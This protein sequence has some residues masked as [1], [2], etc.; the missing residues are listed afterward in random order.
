MEPKL[1]NK[2]VRDNVPEIM[3]A[4]GANPEVRI[5]DD[6]EYKKF[7]RLKLVEE[8]GETNAAKTRED[9][10]KE[11]GDVWEV[12]EALMHNEGISPQEVQVLKQ[13]RREERGGFLKRFFLI[14]G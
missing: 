7:L 8:A 2:L 9:M 12:I 1:Y 11:L 6:A 14:R 5:L 3:K 4:Q 13:K 10:V